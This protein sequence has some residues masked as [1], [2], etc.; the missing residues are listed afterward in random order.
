MAD[1]IRINKV[2]RERIDAYR[3]IQRKN[4]EEYAKEDKRWEK[5]LLLLES[6]S[7]IDLIEQALWMA[8]AGEKKIYK[9]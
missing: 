8:I 3:D 6:M 2:I 4:Y 9:S 7:D 1:T 5:E